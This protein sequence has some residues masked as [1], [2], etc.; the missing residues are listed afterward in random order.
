MGCDIHLYVE[1][2]VGGRWV[3]ADCWT[4]T[5]GW[6]EVPFPKGFY[7]GRRYELFAILADVRNDY[8]AIPIDSPRG[9]PSDCCVEVKECRTDTG[10]DGHSD[11][12]FT[13]QELLDYD[14]TQELRYNKVV[15]AVNYYQWKLWPVEVYQNLF[16]RGWC[17]DISGSAIEIVSEDELRQRLLPLR[18]GKYQE[19]LAVCK[20][21]YA[22]L[23]GRCQWFAPAHNCCSSF[24]DATI[25]RLL[26]VG[27]P[28][29]VRIVF[30]FDN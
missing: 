18:K 24:W 16:P 2:L 4:R 23:Y 19:A 26:R 5:Q 28:D 25:P 22:N 12:W 8:Q 7:E 15:S 11:S 29:Q 3:T 21:K 6:L 10:S 14:W 20:E 30:W 1:K 17:D 13:V 9:L 27:K